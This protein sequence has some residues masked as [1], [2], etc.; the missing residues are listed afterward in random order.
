MSKGNLFLGLASGKIGSVVLYRAFGEERARSWVSRKR[1][2][3]TATQAVQRAIMK[4]CQVSYSSLMP[5]CRQSFQGCGEG[6]PCQAAFVSRNARMLRSMVAEDIAGGPQSILECSKGNFCRKDDYLPPYNPLIISDGGLP[7]IE[8]VGRQGAVFLPEG[9][10]RPA[11]S[12][13]YAEICAAYGLSR[14]D[15]LHV[16]CATIDVVSGLMQSVQHAC[17]IMEPASG[18]MTTPFAAERG[19]AVNSPNAGNYGDAVTCYWLADE[20]EPNASFRFQ[21]DDRYAGVQHIA[22]AI[23]RAHQ[24]GSLKQW[25]PATLDT[26][27]DVGDVSPLGA[28]VASYM[29][30]S[31]YLNGV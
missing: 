30:G 2:P 20:D 9:P 31:V 15:E 11:A 27:D 17:I 22:G 18:D 29:G 6:T 14:G 7:E 19:G 25:S 13:T 23:V 3:R 10:L 1:N 26:V 12:Y 16:V 8:G 28:A 24:A 4:T 21:F 5:L